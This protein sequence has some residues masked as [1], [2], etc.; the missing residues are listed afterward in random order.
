MIVSS[1]FRRTLCSLAGV[2]LIVASGAVR[3]T[4]PDEN[5]AA[6]ASAV[7]AM[8]SA[9]LASDGAALAKLVEDD[10]TYGHSSGRIQ[11]KAAFLKELD[12]T[13]AFRS[14]TLSNQTVRVVGDDAIVRHVFD[15]ENNQPDGKVTTSHIGVLQVWKHR[16][17]GWRLLARQAYLLPKQ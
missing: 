6:V 17:E 16:P 1:S 11:D 12:G 14:L 3:A 15:S 8:R 7:E 2:T 4:A 9:M 5:G 10:L 13:H